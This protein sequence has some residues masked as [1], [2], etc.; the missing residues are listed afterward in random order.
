MYLIHRACRLSQVGALSSLLLLSMGRLSCLVVR[1][2]CCC[3]RMD[4]VVRPPRCCRRMDLVVRHPCCHCCPRAVCPAGASLSIPH[5]VVVVVHGPVV[6]VVVHGPVVLWRPRPRC[7]L[8]GLVV[9]PPHRRH[10]RPHPLLPLLSGGGHVV[11]P[12][13]LSS[14]SLSGGASLSVPHVI[15]V[16]CPPHRRHRHPQAI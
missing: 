14:L 10:R 1:P 7:Y 11:H 4:L 8:V 16:S 13:L 12:P 5:I 15:V 9:C 3:C 2:P 6:V